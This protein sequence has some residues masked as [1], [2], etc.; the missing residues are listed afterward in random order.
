MRRKLFTPACLAEAKDCLLFWLASAL[1]VV[2]PSPAAAQTTHDRKWE[3]EVHGGGMLPTN[4]T[5]GTVNLPG[6]G[7]EFT[8]PGGRTSRRE[9]SWY[10]G[11]GTTLFN[12]VA[13]QTAEDTRQ[14]PANPF[15]RNPELGFSP[16]IIALDT[17][18]GRS[19]G[20][21]ERGG[22]FGV[23]VSRALTLRLSAELSVDYGMVPLQITQANSDAI[24]ATRASFDAAFR[25]WTSLLTTF[26]PIGVS[27]TA[28]FEEGGGRQVF[29]SGA[30]NI[31]LRTTGNIVPYA[32][33][34]AGL[35]ST[36]GKAPSA[37]LTGNYQWRLT[38]LPPFQ[39][40]TFD[41]T[42]SVTVTDTRDE[43]AVA[44]VFGGGVKYHVSRRYGVRLD[45]RVSLTKNSAS[46]LLDT[47]P[48]GSRP[49]SEPSSQGVMNPPTNPTIVFS[50]SPN[51][52]STLS[53]P[54]ITDMPTYSGSG[55]VSTT[56]ITAG[57]FW[58]F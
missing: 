37:T 35:I 41:E 52:P 34:G 50:T 17:L 40:V 29:T 24:E 27:S 1:L 2:L 26:T 23:R 38:P 28:A 19:L 36:T 32:T 58:R 53:G 45:V 22:T 31:N 43:H 39:P 48:L 3:I 44:A 6:P 5:A 15:F 51:V 49:A 9:S 13:S 54:D 8:R 56:N 16:R 57:I 12:Q 11:G 30:L 4:P 20:Q 55:T 21:R 47:H 25:R 42:D 33:V 10:F 14:V 7:E 46:T 18:L